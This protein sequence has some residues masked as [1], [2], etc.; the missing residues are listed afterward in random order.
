[1]T[2]RLLYPDNIRQKLIR[3]YHNHRHVW[4]AG[5]GSWPLTIKLGI[6]SEQQAQ[7]QLEAVRAWVAAWQAW[8][9][10]GEIAWHE[11]RWRIMGVQSLPE[12]IMLNSAHDVVAWINASESWN[13][14]HTYYQHFINRWPSLH[15][16]L[17][18]YF[19][20]LSSYTYHDIRILEKILAWIEANPQSNLY[21]RQLPLAGMDSKWLERRKKIISDLV[22]ALRGGA[23]Q[24]L[25]FFQ[26]CGLRPIPSTMRLR[27]LDRSLREQYG[28]LADITI[29]TTDLAKLNPAISRVYI[30]E[31]LQTGLAFDDLPGA[32]VFM[33][34]GYHVDVFASVPWLQKVSCIYWGDIDTHG[35]AILNRAR[36]Y[37]PH[38]QSILMDEETLHKY[39]LL[40]SSEEKQHTANELPLLT[41]AEQIVY[42]ELKQQRW[43][44]NIR[45][46]QE[47]IAWNDAWAQLAE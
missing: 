47:R 9:G 4:L 35:F 24:D 22:G 6:P 14:V 8:D 45:L 15:L 27:L 25:D 3:H 31:N 17:P 19:D 33:G 10:V 38:L 40:W 12:C 1:M 46:E 28:N 29:P 41:R 18:R 26:Q 20:V 7:Q 44:C 13:K 11:R 23:N 21:P 42:R 2:L 30:V 32:M 34:L 36:H 5:E 16:C 39:Q 43:G 37:L